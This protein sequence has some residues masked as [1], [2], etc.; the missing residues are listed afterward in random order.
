MYEAIREMNAITHETITIN[1]WSF[2][3]T[4]YDLTNATWNTISETTF[5]TSITTI[6][7]KEAAATELYTQ[8]NAYNTAMDFTNITNGSIIEGYIVN[9]ETGTFI[10]SNIAFTVNT[11][12]SGEEEDPVTTIGANLVINNTLG[13]TLSADNINNFNLYLTYKKDYTKVYGIYL[14]NNKPELDE[15]AD[16]IYIETDSETNITYIIA[17]KFS[18]L[19]SDF[20]NNVIQSG[21]K[22]DTIFLEITSRLNEELLIEEYVIKGYA[23]AIQT[24]S[25][26]TGQVES[27]TFSDPTSINFDSNDQFVVLDSGLSSTSRSIGSYYQKVPIISGTQ[28]ATGTTFCT[29]IE[30]ADAISSNDYIVS[31]LET[32]EPNEYRYKLAKIISKKKKLLNNRYVIEFTINTPAYIFANDDALCVWRFKRIEDYATILQTFSLSGFKMTE[33]HMP[34]SGKI[35]AYTQLGQLE[36]ILGVL[37]PANSNLMERLASPDMIDFRYIVDTFNGCISPMNY[38]KTYLSLLA[39]KRQQCLAFINAPSMTEF[40]NSTEPRFSNMPTDANPLPDVDTYYISTGGNLELN[41]AFTYYLPD[42]E[43][44]SKYCAFF[45]PYLTLLEGGKRIIVPPAVYV[46]NLY[47]QKHASGEP[48]K[49]VAGVRRGV[50]SDSKY[51]AM[52]YDF[53]QGDRDYLEPMGINSIIHIP[54][55]GPT[56]YA[57]KLTYQKTASAFNSLHVRDVL[58]TIESD[59]KTILKNYI[60]E[61]NNE[62]TRIE[63]KNRVEAYLAKV[64]TLEGIYTYEVRMNEVNNPDE[65]IN[66]NMGIIDIYVVPQHGLEKIVANV[67]V[68][69]SGEAGLSAFTNVFL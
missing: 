62:Q 11:T 28:S 22:N 2:N 3:E 16:R 46:S 34:A 18:T 8:L 49:I 45:A 39:K 59:I 67:I 15:A 23:S 30:N 38:P 66:A 9:E 25:S 52:E 14:N 35:A 7:L 56:I 69:D 55:V 50:L 63:I 36:K 13:I 10:K 48:F 32:E 12:P 33:A 43:N 53:Q 31:K 29:T 64:Q 65:V 37:D 44:G 21:D 6:P 5:D 61:F 42:E 4:N 58:I 1:D 26:T 41:P 20:K 60:F 68:G 40:A 57:N 27:L 54:N 24:V 19:A 47:V 51:V 17:E